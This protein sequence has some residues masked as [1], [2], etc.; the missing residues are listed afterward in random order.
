MAMDNRQTKIEIETTP[1][2][3][4]D[5][6]KVVAT[7]IGD[8]ERLRSY[9]Q[10]L[11]LNGSIQPIDDIL[12]RVQS[13]SF[14]IA[15]VGE[16]KRGK[17]TF[18]NALLGQDILPSDILPCS[19][20]LNRVTY[21]VTPRVRVVYRDGREEEIAIDK[22]SDYVTKLTPESE[23]TAAHIKEAIVYY[24]VFY[25]QNNVD[26]IDTPGLNDDA[27]MTEVTLSV[28]PHVDAA[29]MVIMAQAPFAE[30]E[31]KFIETKLL[32][33]DLGRIIFVVTGIDRFNSPEDAD[34]SVKYIKDRIRKFVLQR[35]KDQYGEDSPE[36]EV[37]QKK[38]GNPKVIGL[39]AYQALQA[40]Q[41]G[42]GE[43]LLESRFP[44]FEATLEEFL[45]HEKG[46][47]FLQVPINRLIA[48][49]TEILS[50]L[51]LQQAALSTQKEEF[52]AT[53]EQS[54]A[55]IKTL[56]TRNAEEMKLI[57]AAAENV[58]RHVEPLIWQLESEL[59]QSAQQV[60]NLAEITPGELRNKQALIEKLGKQVSNAVEKAAQMQAEKIQDEI[61]RGLFKEM[62]R[63]QE[64]ATSIDLALHRIEMQFLSISTYNVTRRNESNEGV[65]DF[66]AHAIGLEGVAM[67]FKEAGLKGA[68]VGAAGNVGGIFAGVILARMLALTIAGPVG[69][70][71]CVL[72]MFSGRELVKLVF[73]G[74]RLENFKTNYK[75]AVLVEIERQL[76]ENPIDRKINEQIFEIFASLKQK[77]R[78]EVDVL[79][80]NTQNTLT[81]LYAKRERNE[82]LS[83]QQHRDL[84]QMSTE[85]QRILDNAQRLS[86]QL[87]QQV[88]IE[89]A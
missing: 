58:K 72:S 76:R 73:A 47:T 38:I 14:S 46:A 52:Q 75:Q 45:T 62:N 22:L 25:C 27:S 50:T 35:A 69:V 81:D 4:T 54:V 56:R 87:R 79:L 13:N 48:S 6:R 30:S 29:I 43:L 63:L 82:V 36:Y 71:I 3:F 60:I 33:N 39:S 28:L 7:L 15:V 23:E 64:F 86:K 32:A 41:T 44:E 83:E 5:Y 19:A 74:E 68:A 31:Q 70:V 21:G 65:I 61:D 18:I 53:Y 24:P 88:N 34:K 37:Y 80:D 78:Q 67:G 89:S 77:V 40:K 17:S 20:T 85:T 59:K 55:E 84:N 66:V 2:T 10:T 8:L 11:S 9:A 51:N 26:I 12:D 57:D 49:A 1:N 16:F 42:N